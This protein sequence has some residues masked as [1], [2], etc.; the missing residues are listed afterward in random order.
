MSS[1]ALKIGSLIVRTLAKP[2]ANQLKAQAKQH[3]RFRGMCISLAQTMHRNEMRMRINLLREGVKEGLPEPKIRPL[4]EAKAV[5][6]GANFISE[7][8]IFSVAGAL[9]L[10][11]SYRSRQKE[12]NRRADTRSSITDLEEEVT[13]LQETIRTLESSLQKDLE[14]TEEQREERHRRHTEEFVQMVE[15][16]VRQLIYGFSPALGSG[17]DGNGPPIQIDG[18][19]IAA[20]AETV[21]QQV[22][23]EGAA[24]DIRRELREE[25]RDPEKVREDSSRR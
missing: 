7:A 15:D 10:F 19:A 17:Y 20:V 6:T 9:I 16:G 3:E 1:I 23:G 8:F 25:T 21:L 2:V 14:E 24:S 12:L 22:A 11:E 5:D 13:R 18:K 4:N